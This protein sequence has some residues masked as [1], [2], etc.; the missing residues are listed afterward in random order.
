MQA[1]VDPPEPRMQQAAE[2]LQERCLPTYPCL[3]GVPVLDTS[4]C[5]APPRVARPRD[6]RMNGVDGYTTYA[7]VVPVSITE[8]TT[9][10][11]EGVVKA[12]RQPGVSNA[13]L[14]CV[15]LELSILLAM[16]RLPGVVDGS[17]LT[18]LEVFPED[19]TTPESPV[20]ALRYCVRFHRPMPLE[21][22]DALEEHLNGRD[23]SDALRPFLEDQRVSHGP[24]GE[25]LVE[26]F[27]STGKEHATFER[28]KMVLV[29]YFLTNVIR[30]SDL[31]HLI[32]VCAHLLY[33]PGSTGDFLALIPSAS[34]RAEVEKYRDTLMLAVAEEVCQFVCPTKEPMYVPINAQTK[35]A[36]RTNKDYIS[37]STCG[38]SL[39]SRGCG[40]ALPGTSMLT[41]KGELAR[42]TSGAATMLWRTGRRYLWLQRTGRQPTWPAGRHAAVA[43]SLGPWGS[44]AGASLDRHLEFQSSCRHLEQLGAD[45]VMCNEM[46]PFHDDPVEGAPALTAPPL[47]ISASDAMRF[48]PDDHATAAAGDMDDDMSIVSAD[49]QSELKLPH[50]FTTLHTER[51]RACCTLP[52]FLLTTGGESMRASN[53]LR[54]PQHIFILRNPALAVEAALDPAFSTRDA[55]SAM[56]PHCT[57]ALQAVH[58][59]P[60]REIPG[61]PMATEI[62]RQHRLNTMAQSRTLQNLCAAANKCHP[63][64]ECGLTLADF[65]GMMPPSTAWPT[66]QMLSGKLTGTDALFLCRIATEWSTRLPRTPDD[67]SKIAEDVTASTGK[68]C[69]VSFRTAYASTMG[70]VCELGSNGAGSTTNREMWDRHQR[71]GMQTF[72]AEYTSSSGTVVRL[73]PNALAFPSGFDAPQTGD[74]PPLSELCGRLVNDC[75]S[76]VGMRDVTALPLM[77]TIATLSALL[78]VP[79]ALHV[80]AMG[81]TTAGKTLSL[82]VMEH[83][84]GSNV[85]ARIAG[86]SRKAAITG[87]ETYART[88]VAHNEISPEML[89]ASPHGNGGDQSDGLNASTAMALNVMEDRTTTYNINAGTKELHAPSVTYVT[90]TSYALLATSNVNPWRVQNAMMNRFGGP[91][92]MSQ[93]KRRDYSGAA[94]ADAI[95]DTPSQFILQ[96]IWFHLSMIGLMVEAGQLPPPCT[97]AVAPFLRDLMRKHNDVLPPVNPRSANVTGSPGLV[98]PPGN[99]GY[100]NRFSL[101]AINGQTGGGGDVG[102]SGNGAST[103]SVYT[104]LYNARTR[105]TL[106]RACLPT[107]TLARGAM[108]NT[109][110]LLPGA[111]PASLFDCTHAPRSGSR[112]SGPRTPTSRRR[113]SPS[114][115]DCTPCPLPVT[116]CPH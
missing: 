1:E 96:N 48:Q 5:Q 88:T 107:L 57:K 100:S 105:S 9:S 30:P 66:M 78:P 109:V 83:L 32:V 81:R 8:A 79:S 87:D 22:D 18:T 95:V 45:I 84:F 86:Q 75:N 94:T 10:V 47:L 85:V 92:H 25:A 35:Q 69:R 76:S 114:S 21:V 27:T 97:R 51:G 103:D 34:V 70:L 36:T 108:L 82:A 39:V 49:P 24:H 13:V 41:Q 16:P 115:W 91:F 23:G 7:L 55:S 62:L 17:V 112:D 89:G 63:E 99:R 90:N 43:M 33:N 15:H 60:L 59:T 104:A 64:N 67:Y 38:S 52:V 44:D 71:Y 31:L 2:V 6:M 61:H 14:S 113:I 110:R 98:G 53:L 77:M 40:D 11:G 19:R 46:F 28:R 56:M 116:R 37:F 102:G 111:L 65:A 80:F 68:D 29:R 20:V 74:L 12:V 101:D 73:Q 42:T 54:D 3:P 106:L 58:H 26:T 93:A 72:D 50:G 4:G